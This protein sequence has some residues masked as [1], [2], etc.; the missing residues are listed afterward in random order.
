MDNRKS[1]FGKRIIVWAIIA[2]LAVIAFICFKIDTGKLGVT[3]YV[4]ESAEIPEGADGFRIVQLSD[5]HNAK[6]GDGNARLIEAVAGAKPDIVVFTGDIVD[7]N[8]TDVDTAVDL[9][10]KLAELCPVYYVTGNHEYWIGKEAYAELVSGLEKSGCVVL[11]NAQ[12]E[13]GA[14]DD[15]FTLTGLDDMSLHDETLGMLINAQADLSGLSLK[16]LYDG[17]SDEKADVNAQANSSDG[18]FNVVLAHEPQY[19]KYYNRGG[20]DLVLA[21]HA[22]GGQL[23]LPVVGAIYVP[24]QGLFPKI[25]AG[26]YFYGGTEMIVSRGIGNSGVPVRTFN[27]PEIVVVELKKTTAK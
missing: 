20:A 15:S 12:A 3:E 9:A 1:K 23:A 5:L 17:V 4:Y 16:D 14:G 26:E 22:H 21:G 7:S 10:G 25:T 6:F 11:D 13:V 24:D 27:R 18:V 8:R 19:I 2:L